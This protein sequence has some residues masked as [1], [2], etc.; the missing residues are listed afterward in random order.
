M[1]RFAYGLLLS[2]CVI[3]WSLV[4]PPTAANLLL[5]VFVGGIALLLP[6]G[7]LR[8]LQEVWIVASGVLCLVGGLFAATR[9]APQ[10]PL[11][12]WMVGWLVLIL[13]L[14]R[15]GSV[16]MQRAVLPIGVAAGSLFAVTFFFSVALWQNVPTPSIVLSWYDVAG[17]VTLSGC[18]LLAKKTCGNGRQTV[19]GCVTGMALYV[20]HGLLPYILWSGAAVTAADQPLLLAWTRLGWGSPEVILSATGATLCLWQ[21]VT[22]LTQ[23]HMI[24]NFRGKEL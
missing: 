24:V 7:R 20:L 6:G 2:L 15:C 8:R 18:I 9:T 5:T 14:Y 11:W 1:N 16:P 22:V 4:C 21:N 23:T 17:A 12:Q 3:V 19:S 10:I 13:L